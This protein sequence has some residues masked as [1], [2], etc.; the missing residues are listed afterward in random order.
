MLLKLSMHI[1]PPCSLQVHGIL[2]TKS[3]EGTMSQKARNYKEAGVDIEKAERFVSGIGP[4]IRST[5]NDRVCT[6]LGGFCALY[7]QGDHYIASS[8]DGVGTKLLLAQQLGIHNTVGIDLVA[9]SVNDLL[10]SGALPIFFLDYLAT[11][12]LSLEAHQEVVQGI[13]EGCLQA[14]SPLMGGETAEMPGMYPN[15]EFDLAGF[16]VGLL[17]KNF[18]LKEESL[19]PG[20]HL[21]GVA[22]SGFHSNGYSLI[23]S[24]LEGINIELKK[25]LLTPTQIYVSCVRDLLRMESKP[26]KRMAHITGSGFHNIR[27][28][29]KDFNYQITLPHDFHRPEHMNQFLKHL[30]LSPSEAYATFNMG[31][32][33]VIATDEPQV[34]LNAIHKNGL[35][36]WNIGHIEAGQGVIQISAQDLNESI[37]LNDI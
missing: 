3:T 28:I 36:A 37:T 23:R 18:V 21:I 19:K 2:S 35:Q 13:V 11:G 30:D 22:S 12:K 1:M 24:N 6:D 17:P 15:G 34:V 8:T 33:L 27:R 25:K 10:C 14:Q 20:Q 9:M 7:D 4:L 32:G 5:F 31:I 16:A 29:S 26:I